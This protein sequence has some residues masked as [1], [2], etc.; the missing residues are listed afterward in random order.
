M[1]PRTGT[2]RKGKIVPLGTTTASRVAGPATC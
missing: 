1:R 2:T